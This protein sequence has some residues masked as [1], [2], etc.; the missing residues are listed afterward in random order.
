LDQNYTA[1]RTL[2]LRLRYPDFSSLI[3][4][5]L[6]PLQVDPTPILEVCVCHTSHRNVG[7]FFPKIPLCQENEFAIQ[8]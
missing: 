7:Q 3:P 4:L 1:L 2:E 8:H 5:V 6:L